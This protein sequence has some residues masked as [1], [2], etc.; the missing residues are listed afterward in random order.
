MT[1]TAL[2]F[3]SPGAPHPRLVTADAGRRGRPPASCRSAPPAPQRGGCAPPASSADGRTPIAAFCYSSRKVRPSWEEVRRMNDPRVRLA[4]NAAC[5]SRHDVRPLLRG[6]S[7]ALSQVIPRRI[8]AEMRAA[9]HQ[10]AL[11][12]ENAWPS[13]HSW[14]PTSTVGG[15]RAHRRLAPRPGQIALPP[16]RFERAAGRRPPPSPPTARRGC[17]ATLSSA[18]EGTATPAVPRHR[19]PGWCSAGRSALVAVAAPP[20]TCDARERVGTRDRGRSPIAVLPAAP[21]TAHRLG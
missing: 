7:P 13:G 11:D 9:F 14:R 18:L 16:G 1:P 6:A 4:G 2:S 10:R 20:R 8:G 21:S 15:D 19:V 5:I 12:R 17:M 3:T